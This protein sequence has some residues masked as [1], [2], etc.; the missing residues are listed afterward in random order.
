MITEN[1]KMTDNNFVMVDSRDEGFVACPHCWTDQRTDRDF[2][3][4]CGTAFIYKDE[5]KVEGKEEQAGRA[6][7]RSA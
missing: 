6:L 5:S 4:R 7:T 2:C 3:Y 1:K